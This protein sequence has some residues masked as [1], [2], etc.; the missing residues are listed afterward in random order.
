MR[1]FIIRLLI[2]GLAL[3]A[4]A[5]LIGGVQLSADFGDI[6]LVALIFGL[7]NAILKPVLIFFSFPFIVVTLGIFALIVNGA[8]LLITARLT[9]H[10]VVDGLGAAV[11]GS[12]IISIVTMI[13]GGVLRDD[14]GS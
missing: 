13:L 6:L 2:N 10:L 3:S 5:W 9:D 14:T 11:L 8:L 1:N 4:A 12:I 7:L